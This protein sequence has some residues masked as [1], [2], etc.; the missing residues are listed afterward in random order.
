[1]LIPS[2]ASRP[3]AAGCCADVGG[4]S[5]LVGIGVRVCVGVGVGSHLSTSTWKQRG[6]AKHVIQ[7]GAAATINSQHLTIQLVDFKHIQLLDPTR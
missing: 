7:I 4:G 3:N 2:A 1:M 5:G 6:R